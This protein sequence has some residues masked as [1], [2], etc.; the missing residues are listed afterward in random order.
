MSRASDATVMVAGSAS[1]NIEAH[2]SRGSYPIFPTAFVATPLV[3]TLFHR[4]EGFKL[5]REPLLAMA[6]FSLTALETEA[7]GRA[8]AASTFRIEESVLRKIGGLTSTRGDHASARKAGRH[9]KPLTPVEEAWLI[10]AIRA[11]IRHVG[12]VADGG[13]RAQLTM[14]DLL[15]A[16]RPNSALHR[17]RTGALLYSESY[18]LSRRRSAPVSFKR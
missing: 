16:E 9:L 1:F 14:K 6:Y 18:T 4:F 12:E 17:T 13:S 8:A 3:E 2:V 15:S 10:S 7:G 11:V 5:K